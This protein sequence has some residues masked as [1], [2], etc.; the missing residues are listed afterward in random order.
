MGVGIDLVSV[1]SVRESVSEHAEHYLER[2]CTERELGLQ[3][4]ARGSDQRHVDEIRDI[5]GDHAI[6]ACGPA[7]ASSTGAQC[8]RAST[9]RS[10]LVVG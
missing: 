8:V 6:W 10:T 4:R 5:L 1:D 2:V 7:R 9:A 3:E